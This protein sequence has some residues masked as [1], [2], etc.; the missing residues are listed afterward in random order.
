M[1]AIHND[2][3]YGRWSH[4]RRVRHP[5]KNAHINWIRTGVLASLVLFWSVAGLLA[6]RLI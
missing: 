6:W 4:G 5:K 2:E 3:S 1:V